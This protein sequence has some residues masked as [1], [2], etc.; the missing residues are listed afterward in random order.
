MEFLSSLHVIDLFVVAA[1]AAGTFL[2]F[3]Q[4]LLRYAMNCVVVLLAF[5]IASQLRGPLNDV[6]G[7]WNIDPS[8]REQIIYLVLYIGLVIGGWFAARAIYRQTRLPVPRQLD[9]LLGAVLGLLW[10]ALVII[11]LMI[12]MDSLHTTA[13]DAVVAQGGLLKAFYD[14][15]NQSALVE[16]FRNTL[17]PTFGFVVR[18][19]VPG[20]IAQL[21]EAP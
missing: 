13:P 21:L 14:A 17:I 12:V 9:E 1:L 11:F 4:G 8:W 20:D 18:P 15:M 16:L 7:F 5:V 10:A 6:L 3:T 19:F 2:G